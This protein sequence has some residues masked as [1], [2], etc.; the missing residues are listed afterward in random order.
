MR[1][2]DI[3]T[4]QNCFTIDITNQTYLTNLKCFNEVIPCSP[5]SNLFLKVNSSAFLE[6]TLSVKILL[7]LTLAGLNFCH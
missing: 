6:T 3:L 2:L 7:I 4:F 1:C 5:L